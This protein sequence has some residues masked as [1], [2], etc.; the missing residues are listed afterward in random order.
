MMLGIG[1]GGFMDGY[2]KAQKIQDDKE[3]RAMRREQFD[4][5]KVL[6]QRQDD[7][8]N[9]LKGQR[10]EVD[11]INADAKKTFD[12]KVASGDMKSDQFDT[13]Y[14]TY[15]LPKLRNTYLQQGNTEAADRVQKWGDSDAARQGNRLFS[16]ALIKSQTGDGAGALED[17]MKLGQVKGYMD[18]GYQIHGQENIMVDGK[19]TG[20]RIKMTTPDGKDVDQDIA[21][22]DLP[23]MIAT[24]ANPEAA[25]KTQEEARQ[26]AAARK[27]ELED[28][29]TKKLIDKQV[30][31]GDTKVRS[32]AIKAL[33]KRMDG[34]LGGTDKTFDDL[35]SDE[36]ETLISK[37]MGLQT[38][39]PGL[40]GAGSSRADPKPAQ[41][42]LMDRNTG[43]PVVT[44][45]TGGATAAA[46]DSAPAGQR[47]DQ[48]PMPSEG[49]RKTML[50][51]QAAGAVR[52]GANAS[53]VAQQLAQYGIPE[54]E[55]PPEVLQGVGGGTNRQIGLG[56]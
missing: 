26:K 13:F 5:Q 51:S 44:K 8:Y 27:T 30:G 53:D 23:K 20:Y 25:W 28:Y 21:P 49:D 45:S 9:R 2:Q 48:P 32:D 46:A 38:G 36:Q 31:T 1:L 24:F 11:A 18:H 35:S 17:V 12:A 40:A 41:K 37:E 16:S 4:R 54:N 6:N 15:T 7:E 33:R 14:N 52:D 50:L 3:D 39:Q 29:R 34:G 55:W 10:D 19:L 22:G 42:V 56:G 47:A 43:K